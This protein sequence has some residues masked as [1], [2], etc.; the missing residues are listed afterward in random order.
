MPDALTWK[1]GPPPLDKAGERYDCYIRHGNIGCNIGCDVVV[2]DGEFELCWD[3]IGCT[4]TRTPLWH[5]GP[6]PS[7]P[8]GETE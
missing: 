5:F 8:N 2:A 1:P 4:H 7:P 3:D 6:I